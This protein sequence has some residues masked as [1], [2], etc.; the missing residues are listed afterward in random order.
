[1]RKLS[2]VLALALALCMLC[3]CAFANEQKYD[4]PVTVHFVRSTDDTLDTN[5]FS[6]HPDKT[7]TDNLWC[8]LYRDELNI[9]VEYDWIV[10]SGEEYDT[11]LAAELAIGDIPEFVNVTA[12]QV[13]QLYEAGLIMPLEDIYE[14]YA[15]EQTKSVML[16]TGTSPFDAVTFDGH[17]YA[18]PVVGETLMIADLM[19]IRTD[20]LEKLNLEV[21]TT[22]DELVTVAK[23]FCAA[24]FDGNGVD[25]TIGIA[26]Q[27]DFWSQMFTMKGLFNAFDSYP[28]IWVEDEN[29]NLVYGAT[30]PGT[31]D[32]LAALHQMYVDGLIDPEFGVKTGGKVA[33]A[34]TAGKCGIAFGAQWNSIYPLQDSWNLGKDE[35]C[36]WQAFPIP[37]ATDHKAKAMTD[38]GTT[39]WTVVRKDVE[40]PEAVV[41]M[42]NLFIDKCWGPENENGVYYAPL[43]SESIWKL[44]PVTPTKPDKNLN[45][46]LDL[47]AG[48]Q[49][50]D[51][52]GVTGEGYS[53]LQKLQAFES[54]TEAGFALWGWE[55]IYGSGGAYGVLNYYK[56]N[57]LTQDQMFVGAATETMTYMMS[58]LDDLRDEAFVKIILGEEPVDAYDTF[59]ENWMAMG[60]EQITAEVNEWYASV[61]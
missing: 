28:N 33:E 31:K 54:G 15:T 8:D 59:V 4:E 45:A 13:K 60:G 29:G 55:R 30:L 19:W 25:D 57:N 47:E 21:P 24:D 43:D 9:I 6:Q 18:L 39:S 58:T 51:M 26:I 41:K 1:M 50:G 22:W 20:W 38:V 32:A 42:Y 52:S 11:K 56:E 35:G 23:A 14:E 27:K 44:S 37:T 36:Q 61:K 17:L 16:E 48:R 3:S 10:K 5:Y 12:L 49:S 34:T 40:H 46:F 7:M 2:S 53:I